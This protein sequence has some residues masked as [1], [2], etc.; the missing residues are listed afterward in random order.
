[1]D[2]HLFFMRVLFL[3]VA[4]HLSV[5]YIQIISSYVLLVY[6]TYMSTVIIVLTTLPGM[7]IYFV[8]VF[9][10]IDKSVRV[11]ATDAFRSG[12]TVNDVV[13]F[14]KE[15]RAVSMLRL[16]V[17]IMSEDSE[18][19]DELSNLL[20]QHNTDDDSGVI[21]DR[22]LDDKRSSLEVEKMMLIFDTFDVDHSQSLSV[23]ELRMVFQ[24][25]GLN[26]DGGKPNDE[27]DPVHKAVRTI[28]SEMKE[29]AHQNIDEA[30]IGKLPFLIWMSAKEKSAAR[31]TAKNI[32]DY[33]FKKFN[34]VENVGDT[35]SSLDIEELRQVLNAC[36]SQEQRM[37]VGEVSQLVLELDVNDDGEFQEEEFE[38]WIERHSVEPEGS[39]FYQRFMSFCC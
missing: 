3:I 33:V 34:Q 37:S 14:Q 28:L 16:M 32:C 17:A 36:L 26:P 21:M 18:S 25:F 30:N 39:K 38:K 35:E 1:V 6:D 4:V 8:F 22:I 20:Q 11:T 15:A 23:D 7:I 13:R 2:V 9:D 5:F 12:R 19:K 24:R 29:T 10:I 27:H 31:L